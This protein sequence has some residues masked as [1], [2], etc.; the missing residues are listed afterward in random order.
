MILSWE[1]PALATS[2]EPLGSIDLISVFRH[3]ERLPVGIA[4]SAQ[5]GELDMTGTELAAD[6]LFGRVPVIPPSQFRR[7]AR[8]IGELDPTTLGG[9]TVGARLIVED[10]PPIVGES[11]ELLRHTY[12][13][14][15]TAEGRES[16]LS[17]L[18]SIVPLEVSTAP[19]GVQ[20][21]P[22]AGG[23]TL[24]WEEA[25]SS[26]T[27]GEP[28]ELGWFRVY[29]LGP[30]DNALT[31]P[32]VSGVRLSEPGFV[33]A[34]PYGTWRYGV[35]RV[36]ADDPV[37]ESELSL[38]VEVVVSDLQGPEPPTNLRPL[39]EARKVRLVWTA[40]LSEDA[41]RYR[42]YRSTDGG[43]R[44]LMTELDGREANTWTDE[45]PETGRELVYEVTAIDEAGNE[46]EPVA[47][48]SVIVRGS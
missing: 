46:S 33:D 24:T 14:T 19:V 12:G 25:S 20:V 16:D 1:F 27:G 28:T 29:R 35:T 30:T 37:R 17:N 26:I 3:T 45:T 2:G 4:T 5:R 34:A 32:P 6:E 13:V 23:V 7:L 15:T 38:L 8:R 9:A 43:E 44:V 10:R 18:V 41:T 42:V 11:G 36:S 22:R 48:E 40:S 31:A 39:V 21:Q 47:T